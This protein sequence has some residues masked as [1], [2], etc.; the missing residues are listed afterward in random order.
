MNKIRIDWMSEQRKGK[1][2]KKY[3]KKGTIKNYKKSKKRWALKPKGRGLVK[4]TEKE[5]E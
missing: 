2:D 5:K 1:F 3:K 4:I